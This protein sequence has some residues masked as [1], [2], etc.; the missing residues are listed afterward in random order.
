MNLDKYETSFFT[1][2]IVDAVTPLGFEQP[3]ID[4]T[5][6]SLYAVFGNC[7]SPATTVIL[8]GAVEQLQSIA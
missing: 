7:C 1:K 5:N 8:P 4:F 3:D 2:Q 6:T